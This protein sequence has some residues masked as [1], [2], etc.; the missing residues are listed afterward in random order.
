TGTITL[1]GHLGS[2][3]RWESS[4]N[5]GQSWETISNTGSSLTYNDVRITTWFRA[6]VQSGVCAPEYSGITVITMLPGVSEVRMGPELTET[7]NH[8][9]TITFISSATNMGPG[10][11]TYYWY[12]DD[13]VAGTSNPFTYRF[14]S[15]RDNPAAAE[16]KVYAVAEN[17]AGCKAR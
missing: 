7:C 14:Q 15:P 13:Q 17:N 16:F 10:A 9:T 6:V 2:V 8:D 5:N 1:S 12:V 3:K 11:L 4:I